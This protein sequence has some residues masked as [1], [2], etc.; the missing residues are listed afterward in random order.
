MPRC[1]GRTTLN[2]TEAIVPRPHPVSE[3]TW[4]FTRRARRTPRTPSTPARRGPGRWPTPTPRNRP[5]AGRST[6]TRRGSRAR[7]APHLQLLLPHR[8]SPSTCLLQLVVPAS[9]AGDADD[10]AMESFFAVLQ[11]NVLNR[12][13]WS[14]RD[15]LRSA[16]ITWIE[17]TYHHRRRQRALGK[18]PRSGSKSSSARLT[19]HK[20]HDLHNRRR[21]KSGQTRLACSTGRPRSGSV[22]G[23]CLGRREGVLVQRHRGARRV[24]AEVSHQDRKP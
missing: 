1:H 11:N 8:H 9:P 17:R 12:Q 3:P 22:L 10:A 13:T 7:R 5:P 20:Q 4:T 16:T 23:G 18:L 6:P 14:T 19:S 15:E 21:P 24:P 2:R